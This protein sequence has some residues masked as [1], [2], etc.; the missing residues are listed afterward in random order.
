MANPSPSV[1]RSEPEPVEFMRG[2]DPHAIEISVVL[3]C[4]NEE[5]SVAQ[6]VVSI[7]DVLD[8][9]GKSYEVIVVDNGSS[10]HSAARAGIVGARVVHEPV[11]GYGSACRA[12]LDAAKGRHLVLG[13]ADGTYDFSIVPQLVALLD[14]G[15]DMVLGN[16]LQGNMEPGAMPWA[17]RRI[18]TPILTGFVNV[19]FGTD[20]G[21]VNCGIRAITRSAYSRLE[22]ESTGMEFASEMVVRATQRDLC[23]AELPVDY[24]RRRSGEA[25]L[26]T[27]ADGWR[28]LKLVAGSWLTRGRRTVAAAPVVNIANASDVIIELREADEPDANR[29]RI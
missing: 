17:H 23:L 21:D 19:L 6:C 11:A 16:R 1:V 4:L 3:P 10:D 28:H 5:A 2:L 25:K 14:E 15:A 24:R 9:V 7:Q 29:L 18:G 20:I 8:V 27:W 13:D 12:G 26:R 22:V